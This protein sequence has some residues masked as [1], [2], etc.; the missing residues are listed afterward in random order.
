MTVNRRTF[1][2]RSA[3]IGA[4]P[5]VGPLAGCD[6]SSEAGDTADAGSI[7][8]AP[9]ASDGTDVIELPDLPHYSHE[10]ELGPADLFQH[11]VASGDPLPDA[12]ILWTRCTT[13]DRGALEVWWEISLDADFRQ[14]VQ[15]GTF[16]TDAGIDFTVKLDV[17]DLWP[18]QTYY[19]RFFALGL[20]SPIG[21]TR[22]AP[23]GGVDRLRF[24][25][26]SC[27]SYGHGYFH[28]YRRI[29]E[30]ADIDAVIHLGDYIYEY[31]SGQYGQIRGYDPPHETVT[32]DDY[33]RRYAHYRLD[34][35]LAE[36][37]R[38]HPW[39][40]TWDDHE[41]ANNSSRDEAQNHTEGRE[42]AWVDRKAAAIQA[43]N[44]WLPI[45][46]DIDDEGRIWRTLRF[47]DL[48]DLFMLDT[49]LWGRDAEADRFDT[50]AHTDPSRSLLG[51][52]Q[53]AWLLGEL[54]GSSSQW[55]V[56]GQ[57]VMMAEWRGAASAGQPGPIFNADQWDGY[58]P[59]RQRVYDLLAAEAIS[60]VVVLTG[61]IHTSWGND[62]PAAPYDPETYDPETGAG[63]LA[64]EFVTP[65]VTS[66]GLGQLGEL[67]GPGLQDFNPHVRFVDLQ[68]RGYILLDV[69]PERCQGEWFH[70]TTVESLE[71]EELFVA[72]LAT[73]SDANHLRA[74]D[75]P[76]SAPTDSPE[77]AP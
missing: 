71:S 2:R 12:V 3:A 65:G 48:L 41:S 55:R 16:Q 27:A 21:R 28:A 7:A 39:I 74:V 47:G 31:G 76:S 68:R 18:G 75:G 64:V 29:A 67:V 51:D 69:T 19:Y 57:Q 35:D 56:L 9:D 46:S 52:D 5:L 59:S 72:A 33:R 34:Q 23:E 49:R 42:G 50:E 32:L 54:S 15:V 25:V 45:R 1:L 30:R 60:N 36:A 14:R 38:Q 62:L 8:D 26:C 37:H 6:E 53:E 40:H 11:G 61:D 24:A 43:F 63:S 17:Q 10:G 73:Q 77:L 66:P 13:E 44:E 70:F 20:M 58:A 4:I 22:T